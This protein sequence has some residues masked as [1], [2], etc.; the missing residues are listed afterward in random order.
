MN[1]DITDIG[2]RW[3]ACYARPD[4][5]SPLFYMFS[6]V[7]RVQGCD[8]IILYITFQDCRT[9]CFEYVSLS[10]VLQIATVFIPFCAIYHILSS[11][12]I[13][14]MDGGV[15]SCNVQVHVGKSK[16]SCTR[17]I[18]L[19]FAGRAQDLHLYLHVYA[20]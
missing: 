17:P 9:Y 13:G 20:Y 7:T 6:H 4:K 12:K 2:T 10:L 5:R 15:N 3:L 8:Q 1:P 11:F 18:E 16:S 19:E 14:S